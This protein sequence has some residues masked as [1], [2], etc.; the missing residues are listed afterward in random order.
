[1]RHHLKQPRPKPRQHARLQLLS[2]F[3][4]PLIQ[5]V[6]PILLEPLNAWSPQDSNSGGAG[7]KAYWTPITPVDEERKLEIGQRSEKI[8]F[9]HEVDRVKR[10]GYPESRVVWIAKDNP[11]ADYDILSVDKNGKDLWLEV[12]STMGR[13]GHFQWSIA[14]LKKA[15]QERERYILW[16]VYEV[17]TTHPSIKPFRDPIGMIIRHGIQLDVASLSAEVEP[18][19][20]P[21]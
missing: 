19:R 3:A 17:G 13:H 10:L 4:L 9:L 11:L 6:T 1:M 2:E 18:L 5:S 20:V 8:I 15:M 16:R 7:R 21:D 14:E 12:K